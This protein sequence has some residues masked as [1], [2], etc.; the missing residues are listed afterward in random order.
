MKV[1]RF[2]PFLLFSFTVL[3]PSCLFHTE[4]V[5]I[6]YIGYNEVKKGNSTVERLSLDNARERFV[7]EK[8]AKED[9]YGYF[10]FYF[11]NDD[12]ELR[13]SSM[14][15]YLDSS[16]TPIQMTRDETDDYQYYIFYGSK[17]IYIYFNNASEDVKDHIERG[18]FQVQI[19]GCVWFYD[20]SIVRY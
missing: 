6:Y 17:T 5:Q 12:V 19:E 15:S 9:E 7:W 20:K 14:F 2:F 8:I 18:D 11:S 4:G 3:L 10:D 16:K 13:N 1:K